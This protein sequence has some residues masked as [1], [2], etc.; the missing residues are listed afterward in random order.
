[1]NEI[2]VFHAENSGD[3]AHSHRFL[4]EKTMFSVVFIRMVCKERGRKRRRIKMEDTKKG[5]GRA[6]CGPQSIPLAG[7]SPREPR[8]SPAIRALPLPDS[9]LPAE[10][11]QTVPARSLWASRLTPYP[12]EPSPHARRRKKERPLLRGQTIAPLPSPLAPSGEHL[13]FHLI[14]PLSD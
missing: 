9:I 13:A 7:P 8:R 2:I 3:C 10:T 4:R 1:M 6:G 5:S 14:G 11:H 12:F